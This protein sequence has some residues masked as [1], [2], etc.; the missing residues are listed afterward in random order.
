MN[1][2]HTPTESAQVESWIDDLAAH[3]QTTER[4]MA[5]GSAAL[6]PLLHYLQR[7]PQLVSQPRV[8][9]RIHRRSRAHR[10]R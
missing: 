8:F 4:I 5:M 2:H 9:A 7:G 3:E 10:R 6:E 1:A